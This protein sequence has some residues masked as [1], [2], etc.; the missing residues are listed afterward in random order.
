LGQFASLMKNAHEIR[1][2]MEQLQEALR[3][4][5]V[6]GSAGGGM[7]CV[8]M[9]AQQKALACRIDPALLAGGAGDCEVLE[10]LIVAAFNQATEKSR[11][12]A[13]EE[14]SKMTDGLGIGDL[15]QAL[16]RFGLGG[17]RSPGEV[18]EGA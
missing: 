11:Q 3:R 5:K 10:D 4:L 12:A 9:N 7:V 13:A 15:G 6:E 1:G 2:R 14:M 17:E 8:E 16:S 18:P